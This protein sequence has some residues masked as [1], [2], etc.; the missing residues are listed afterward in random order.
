M[1]VIERGHTAHFPI[2]QGADGNGRNPQDKN[3]GKG[4]DKALG[5]GQ[6]GV[7]TRLD[8]R[9][10]AHQSSFEIIVLNNKCL[11]SAHPNPIPRNPWSNWSQVFL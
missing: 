2:V 8:K 9:F 3:D 6:L 5:I 11:R 4:K 7:K 1:P 10:L